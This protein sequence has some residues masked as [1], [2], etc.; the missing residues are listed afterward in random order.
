M[1]ITLQDRTAVVTGAAKG[2]GASIAEALAAAGAAV[3][4]NYRTDEAAAQRVVARITA[5][6]GRALAVRADVGRG[7]DVAELFAAARKAYG[8]VDLL[9]NNAAV[10]TFAPLGAVSEADWR[11]Q[12]DTNLWGP[13]QTMQALIGQPDLRGPASVINVSTAGTT[14]HPPYSAAY[15]ASKAGLEAA[16]LVAAKELGPRGIRVNTIAPSVS[17]T[18]GTR[19]M[20]FIGSPLADAAVTEIPL[21]RLGTPDD[22]GPVAV[23][24]ASDAARWVSGALIHVSGGQR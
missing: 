1:E 15:V 17:D 16:T 8:V 12:T 11:R 21:G 19:A 5:A 24:L 22:Y 4:V 23:F 3:V 20:G 14:S 9:V 10:V 7:E 6:G 18:D 2:I 13:M